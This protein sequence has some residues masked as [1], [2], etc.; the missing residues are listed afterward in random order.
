MRSRELL[1]TPLVIVTEYQIVPHEN[2]RFL[3]S[4]KPE[5]TSTVYQFI[6]NREPLLEE[7][8][9]YNIGYRRDEDINWIDMSATA[10]AD[11]VDKNKSHYFARI[12]GEEIR[13][14]ETRKSDTRVKHRSQDAHYLGRKYAWRIY[15]MAVAQETFYAYLKEIN[16]PSVDC[17]TDNTPSIAYKEDGLKTAIDAFIDSAVH[18]G[19]NRFYSSL[20]PF[21]KYFL[22]KGIS[23]ITD[24]K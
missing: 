13:E 6:A 15:G 9:R 19:S 21:K 24:K 22:V 10:K 14:S 2:G 4:F 5:T 7:G 20:L 3:H 8:Q 18:L 1:T 23:A 11:D 17:L 16:H 12:K